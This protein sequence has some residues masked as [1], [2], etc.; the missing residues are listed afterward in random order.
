MYYIIYYYHTISGKQKSN[1]I[2]TCLVEVS[3][4]PPLTVKAI[5]Q[6]VFSFTG[7]Q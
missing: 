3:A 6:Q 2:D 5:G 7:S 4:K 1:Q